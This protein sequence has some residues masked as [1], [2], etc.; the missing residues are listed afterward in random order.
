MEN[1]FNE[2]DAISHDELI[3]ILNDLNINL[4]QLRM[5]LYE[6]NIKFEKYKVYE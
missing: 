6:E 1:N 4:E 5:N 2:Y 3:N